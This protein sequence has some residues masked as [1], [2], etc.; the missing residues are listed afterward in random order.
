MMAA[1]QIPA[2]LSGCTSL[3]VPVAESL[4]SPATKCLGIRPGGN[5]APRA[6]YKGGEWYLGVYFTGLRGDG[7]TEAYGANLSVGIDV[8]RILSRVPTAKQGS[9]ILPDGEL[10]EVIGRI[11]EVFMQGGSVV[12]NACRDAYATMAAASSKP[13]DGC[14][15]ERFNTFTVGSARTESGEW[16][17]AEPEKSPTIYVASV[18]F[19]GL[20]FYKLNSELST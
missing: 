16:I 5:G 6:A 14:Y 13:V 19:S 12:A 1:F 2:F 9:F 20:K 10:W 4:H 8:T 18:A 11:T 7:T 17:A 3:L 15:R